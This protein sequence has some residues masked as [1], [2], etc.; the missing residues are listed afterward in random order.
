LG[1]PDVLMG[2]QWYNS[3]FRNINVDLIDAHVIEFTMAHTKM[4]IAELCQAKG[5]PCT[6]VNSPVDFYEDP[7]IK[8]RGF[9]IQ[10]EHPVIGRYSYPGPP[11]RLS[12]TP[13][14]TGRSAP[15]LGQ[16]NREIYCVELGYSPDEL[17]AF[18]AEG[19]I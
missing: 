3:M 13:C 11:Y 1:N 14:F 12:A 5:V 9:F 6:P 19:T 18:K 8:D 17:A 4:E 16:H 10:N 15:L 2:E 7:H